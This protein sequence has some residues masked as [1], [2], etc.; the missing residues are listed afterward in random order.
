MSVARE[1]AVGAPGVALP[2]HLALVEPDGG[3][4]HFALHVRAI[5]AEAV[6][7]GWRI[8]LLTTAAAMRHPAYDVVR[9][10][11]GAALTTALL[12]DSA[13]KRHE[14]R[15]LRGLVHEARRWRAFRAATTDVL[16]PAAVDAAY[17]GSLE[18]TAR[19]FALRGS[20]FGSI[21]FAGMYTKVRFHHRRMGVRS[22]IGP[23]A[24]VIEAALFPRLLAIP[25]L[26]AVAVLDEPLMKWTRMQAAP[27]WR[28]LVFVRDG[29]GLRAHPERAR[30]R[31]ALGIAP[32]QL[33]VLVYGT[34]EVRKGVPQ[35]VAAL[36]DRRMPTT[37]A[38]LAAGRQNPFARAVLAA[39]PAASLR[40][41]GRLYEDPEFLDD[42]REALVF[43]A[44]DIVWIAYRDFDAM[45]GVMVQAAD[46]G[47]PCLACDRGLIGWN[48]A[49]HGLGVVVDS[50][51][52]DA[53][54]EGLL[55]L[56]GDAELRRAYG[57]R[58]RVFAAGRTVE[59]FGAG[60]CDAVA[61]T[62]TESSPR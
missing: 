17:V 16:A 31:A 1:R 40:S 18:Q 59:N 37:V 33:I 45:S 24:R 46:V 20:P 49:R 7:R 5:A 26:R 8:T 14:P 62:V 34:L 50:S 41:Q 38:M 29:S 21:P 10:E 25:T 36:A 42:A 28:K 3:G 60:I 56:V 52:H 2:L 55:R 15:L 6:R 51:R 30:A 22:R 57:E 27:S 43:A 58:G 11:S 39:E 44:A 47:L 54:V 4:H 61:R 53:V 48:V 13:V 32:E 23:R 9:D 35:L 19:L 12:P